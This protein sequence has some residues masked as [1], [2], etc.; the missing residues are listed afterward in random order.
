MRRQR[1]QGIVGISDLIV[2]ANYVLIGILV[3][4]SASSGLIPGL[5]AA[6][7]RRRYTV[8]PFFIG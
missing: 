6:N 2:S 7:K 1:H 5:R 8:M 4:Y 3:Q